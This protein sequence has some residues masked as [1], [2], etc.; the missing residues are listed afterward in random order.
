MTTNI[1][2]FFA[3]G[4]ATTV[5]IVLLM[6]LGKAFRRLHDRLDAWHGIE[7]AY[8]SGGPLRAP[9]AAAML[10]ILARF[11]RIGIMLALF[12]GYSALMLWTMPWGRSYALALERVFI[13]AARAMT[14]A[15][16]LHFPDAVFLVIVIVVTY[17][18]VKSARF[19][20]SALAKGTIRLPGF[21][22]DWA[23]PT[24]KI[25]RGLLLALAAVVIFHYLPGSN[26]P[27][28]EGVSLFLGFLLSLG[29][30]GAIS[31]LVAGGVL[32]YTRAFQVGDR[33][34]I[35]DSE[36]DV[37]EK[38]LLVTRIRT[39]KNVDISV[40][41]GS[42]LGR[43]IVNYSSSAE[44]RG[45]ILHTTVTIGY[46]VPWRSVHQLLIDAALAT[47]NVLKEPQP[48]VL[49]TG[50]DDFYAKYQLNAYTNRPLVSAQT[51]SDL[52]QNIQ[53]TLHEA[54]VEILSPHYTAIRDGNAAAM[55]R[56]YLPEDYE[57]PTFRLLPPGGTKG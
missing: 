15:I 31:H 51:Y 32:T 49:Q 56:A 28:F 47:E 17:V 54:G 34:Q 6:L 52:H 36:G 44:R 27:A 21:Y 1:V 37:I 23:E 14:N 13:A 8:R 11:A 2:S 10:H 35:G 16:A 38:T 29:S 22:A 50:L 5:L 39:I 30:S 33:I 4:F 41:N 42:V 7:D 57:A 25:V 3:A 18:L 46:D 26:S 55:P 20:F 40:P 12:Y 53:D 24:Y 19:I 43:Q 9:R 48:Y 45:L